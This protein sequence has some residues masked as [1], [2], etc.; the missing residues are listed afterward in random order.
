LNQLTGPS[1]IILDS[2]HIAT[3]SL[4]SNEVRPGLFEHKIYCL[5]FN[6]I[7]A[8][9]YYSQLFSMLVGMH[10]AI[11]LNRILIHSGGN[12]K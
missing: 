7:A 9:C 8:I 12:Q 3:A 11:S 5:N 2:N 10:D 6:V 1:G 4:N